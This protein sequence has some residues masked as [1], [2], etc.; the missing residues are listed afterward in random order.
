M[1]KLAREYLRQI[2]IYLLKKLAAR[3]FHAWRGV[4]QSKANQRAFL[5]YAASLYCFN[6]SAH[7]AQF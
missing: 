4:A 2:L 3:V 7:A 1:I 6:V 5:E